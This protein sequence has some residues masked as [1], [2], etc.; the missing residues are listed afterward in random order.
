MPYTARHVHRRA[1]IRFA[2][3]FTIMLA[4]LGSAELVSQLAFRLR[5]GYWLTSASPASMFRKTPMARR[6]PARRGERGARRCHD[7]AQFVGLRG[8]EVAAIKPCGGRR[9]AA[10]GGSTTYGTRV[11]DDEMWPSL[12][13]RDLGAGWEVLN[14]AVPG[15]STVENVIQS[16]FWLSD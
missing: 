2:G 6:H 5:H 11:L 9:I 15:Y 8:N 3:C 13:Q 4:L 1:L 12:L 10:L 7:H 14:L 16:A